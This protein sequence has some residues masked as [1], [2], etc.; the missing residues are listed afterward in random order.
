MQEVPDFIGLNTPENWLGPTS[1][2]L[3]CRKGAIH[4]IIR[5]AAR[6]ATGRFL[7]PLHRRDGVL[8][9]A[10][11]VSVQLPE[12]GLPEDAPGRITRGRVHGARK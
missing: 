6:H 7:K 3:R 11:A 2:A 1:L 4:P 8:R 12:I 9:D 5:F 10:Q